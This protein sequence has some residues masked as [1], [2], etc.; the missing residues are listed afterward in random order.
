MLDRLLIMLLNVKEKRLLKKI[1][2]LIF[3]S[4][5]SETKE[6]KNQLYPLEEQTRRLLKFRETI[7]T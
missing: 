1:N 3:D 7:G 2:T 5:Y 6:L 4:E